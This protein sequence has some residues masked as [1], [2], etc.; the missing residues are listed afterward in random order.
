M[1]CS[2]SDPMTASRERF[3]RS[4]MLHGD[5]ATPTTGTPSGSDPSLTMWYT[6]GNS[7]FLARSP[8]M[9]NR[10]RASL[11]GLPSSAVP[12]IAFWSTRLREGSLGDRDDLVHDPVVMGQTG[13]QHLVRTG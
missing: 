11:C 1:C 8:V 5:E 6:A 13:E 3:R 2:P 12:A 4:S 9:P 10:T 7:F